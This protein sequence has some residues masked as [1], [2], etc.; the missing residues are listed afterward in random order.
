MASRDALEHVLRSLAAE[1]D[2]GKVHVLDHS[3]GSWLAMEA[4]RRFDGGDRPVG[5]QD[6][7]AGVIL[8]GVVLLFVSRRPAR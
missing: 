7:A 6:A 1:P 5:V 4:L 2:V 3:M 8:V